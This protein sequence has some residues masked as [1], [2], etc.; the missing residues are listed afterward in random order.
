MFSACIFMNYFSD[1]TIQYFADISSTLYV[2]HT[3]QSQICVSGKNLSRR[4]MLIIGR[5]GFSFSETQSITFNW[6]SK[7]SVHDVTNLAG[8]AENWTRFSVVCPLTIWH[9]DGFQ[10]NVGAEAPFLIS[11]LAFG[12]RHCFHRDQGVRV[13]PS[14][15][16]G[17]VTASRT[18][19]RRE[20][21]SERSCSLRT[22]RRSIASVAWSLII[23]SEFGTRD[24]CC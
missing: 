14:H 7:S 12:P 1:D 18:D 3:L 20:E 11:F 17:V 13:S 15:L 4:R 10:K 5:N 6:L 16:L 2:E 22:I 23:G 24:S 8:A 19:Y 21:A 9:V